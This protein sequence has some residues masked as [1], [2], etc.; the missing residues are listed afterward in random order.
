[1]VF[2]LVLLVFCISG[3]GVIWWLAVACLLVVGRLASWSRG[4]SPTCL[5]IADGLHL[6]G[7]A[8]KPGCQSFQGVPRDRLDLSPSAL[9][10][11]CHEIILNSAILLKYQTHRNNINLPACIH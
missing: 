7:R 4:D 8:Y 11:F 2:G 5:L 6:G 1:M 3:F 10:F 9:A